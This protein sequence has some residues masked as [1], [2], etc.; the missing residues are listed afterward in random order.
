MS[1]GDAFL[2]FGA[3]GGIGSTLSRRLISQGH[4]VLLVGRD[5]DKL[6]ALSNEL[7]Q[8]YQVADVLETESVDLAF[9]EAAQA[10]SKI[11]GAVNCVG[12]VLLKPAHLTTPEEFDQVIST[13]LKSSFCILRSAVK[14]FGSS[15]GSIVLLSSAAASIGLANHEAIAAAKA[16]INGLVLSAAATYAS[17]SIRVNGVAPGLVET[18]LTTAITTSQSSRQYSLALHPVG[19]LGKPEDIA[20][21]I[22]WLLSSDQSWVTGQIIGVDGGLSSLKVKA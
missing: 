22:E 11:S 12:S 9:E 17:K 15:G 7:D 8:P 6:I 16:G 1:S 18:E 14:S 4:Q 3:Y 13:N 21:C 20:S 10:F 19:R 5:Q 2:V